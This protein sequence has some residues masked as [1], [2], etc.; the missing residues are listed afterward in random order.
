MDDEAL[1]TALAVARS[2]GLLSGWRPCDWPDLA[3]GFLLAGIGDLEIAELAGLPASVTGWETDPL[4]ASLC[5]KHGVPLP[6]PEEAV[7]LLA[8]LMATDLRLRPAAVTAPMI[9]MVA[10]L[11]MVTPESDLANQ[12]YRSAEYLDCDCVP[13]DPGLEAK[14]ENLTPLALPGS[15]VQVL[16]RSIRS[17]LP[18]SQ[19]PH[20]H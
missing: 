6:D 13:V 8:H 20:G 11:A 19:P 12:C 3:V 16:A 18:R 10:A 14:L 7:I 9:R 2:A 4:V 1:A 5:E 15:L 17:T